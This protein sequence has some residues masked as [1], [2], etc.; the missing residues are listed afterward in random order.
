MSGPIPA[1]GS[2]TFSVLAPAVPTPS[3]LTPVTATLT[4][5]T[6]ADTSPHTITLTEEPEGAVLAFDTSPTP[7]FGS[8]VRVLQ[9]ASQKFNVTNTGNDTANVA[10]TTT[11]NGAD[12][13]GAPEPLEA[14]ADA[15]LGETLPPAFVVSTSMFAIGAN[16]SQSDSVTFEPTAA[17][18]GRKRQ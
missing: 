9:A 10:L 18:N 16:G 1:G 8:F 4:I 11:Q 3:P 12:D 2:F 13:A 5:V 14:G 17:A 7:N 15:T 6:D